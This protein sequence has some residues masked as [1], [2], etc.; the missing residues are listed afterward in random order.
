MT[1]KRPSWAVCRSSS[2]SDQ[3]SLANALRALICRFRPGYL[4]RHNSHVFQ[5]PRRQDA[6]STIAMP[7]DAF[8]H[9]GDNLGNQCLFS[10]CRGLPL[11]V[12]WKDGCMPKGRLY[13]WEDMGWMGRQNPGTRSGRKLACCLCVYLEAISNRSSKDSSC[14]HKG[15]MTNWL[16][17][18]SLSNIRHGHITLPTAQLSTLRRSRQGIER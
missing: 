16:H 17:H 8:L 2:R 3:I 18:S 6:A 12:V 15:L 1:G 11:V 5:L 7:L 14:A 9:A 13:T 4:L 10:Q